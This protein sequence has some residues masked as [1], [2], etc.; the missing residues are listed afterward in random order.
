MS[1][2]TVLNAWQVALQQKKAELEAC[3]KQMQVESCS[4]CQKLLQC[5]LRDL[6]VKVVYESM[7]KGSGG[8][9]EF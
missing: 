1:S 7:S 8:G 2:E 3:Q 4:N 6:Y 5:E 9:F